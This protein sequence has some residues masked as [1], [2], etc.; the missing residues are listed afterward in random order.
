MNA[1]INEAANNRIYHVRWPAGGYTASGVVLKSG[2][3]LEGQGACNVTHPTGEGMT[4]IL[5]GTNVSNVTV[6]G[7]TLDGNKPV[8]YAGDSADG[9]VL[10]GVTN[11]TIEQ[12]A[13]SNFGHGG[14]VA[15]NGSTGITVQDNAFA[16]NGYSDAEFGAACW[17]FAS[18][19]GIVRRNTFDDEWIGVALDDRSVS[20]SPDDGPI[21]DSAVRDNTIVAAVGVLV[22]GVQD[23]CVVN[24]DI[25]AGR[26]VLVYPEQGVPVT[27]AENVVVAHNTLRD[28]SMS[29]GG[30]VVGQHTSLIWGI[31]N[32]YI[33]CVFDVVD[34]SAGNPLDVTLNANEQTVYEDMAYQYSDDGTHV[35]MTSV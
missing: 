30:L 9:I 24:N 31:E 14:V 5:A 6:R 20:E 22:A 11:A 18:S 17:L 28:G 15:Q 29:G 23:S 8:P 34:Q 12:C 35:R 25:T 10:D 3:I 33:D 26:G 16:G 4:P 19:Q 7:L 21:I 1:A 13:V 32:D 2:V 27:P